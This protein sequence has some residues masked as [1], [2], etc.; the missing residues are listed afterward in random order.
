MIVNAPDC[1]LLPKVWHKY[2]AILNE[3]MINANDDIMA[4][5]EQIS[6]RN[7][8]FDKSLKDEP[9]QRPDTPRQRLIRI[10]DTMPI[11]GSFVKLSR[12]CLE[13]AN[14]FN[15]LVATCFEWAASLYRNGEAR[16][17]TVARLL[18]RCNAY[19]KPLD[20]PILNFLASASKNTGIFMGAVYRIIAE[21][22]R[23]KH[24]S[25]SRLLSWLIAR[26]GLR[27]I[28]ALEQVN[29]NFTRAP[30]KTNYQ[31]RKM[32]MP[33]IFSKC[34]CKVWLHMF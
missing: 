16:V 20:D 15:L 12:D 27:R 28:E 18:R 22:L 6:K 31:S 2:E 23:S 3:Q 33:N 11:N 34:P 19:E 29:R 25:A 1:F 30:S 32:P 7:S 24:F 17:Y 26:G 4:S 9:W 8:C 13:T 21:L 10:L 5:L 14:D